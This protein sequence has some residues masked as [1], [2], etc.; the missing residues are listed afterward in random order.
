M[1]AVFA[2]LK[3]KPE[4]TGEVLQQLLKLRD[5]AAA[6]PGAREYAV[7]RQ[8]DH[9][10]LVYERYVDQAAC[11]VHFAAPYVAEFLE[12]SKQWL[13]DAPQVAFGSLLADFHSR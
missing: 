1:I 8:P 2:L 6:E 11:D 5:H 10:F 13:D 12:Q 9:G 3:A 4:Y 7:H